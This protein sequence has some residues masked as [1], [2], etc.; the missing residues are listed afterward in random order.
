M[1]DEIKKHLIGLFDK[2]KLFEKQNNMK[3]A[4]STYLKA[5]KIY[6]EYVSALNNA[7]AIFA[8]HYLKYT[9]SLECYNRA[10][11]N[12]PKNIESIIGKGTVMVML[13]NIDDAIAYYKK[14]LT[15]NAKNVDA[16]RGLSSVYLMQHEFE[17]ALEPLERVLDILPNDIE[18]LCN[19]GIVLA[20]QGDFD[21]ADELFDRA[22]EI[23]P[24]NKMA[25]HNKSY[26]V[27]LKKHGK[28]DK[29]NE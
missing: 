18:V 11:R 29:S 22:L 1:N 5:L 6:P 24:A 12:D 26:F 15:L 9:E 25:I 14:A 17:N 4:L 27:Y 7:G 23:E 10:L 16:L 2:A 20:E 21:G 28:M 19:K 13:K 3:D 8:Q